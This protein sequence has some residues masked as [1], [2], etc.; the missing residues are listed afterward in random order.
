MIVVVGPEG[1][2]T[3]MLTELLNGCGLEAIQRSL[4]YAGVWWIG[5]TGVPETLT[6]P[7][8]DY[9]VIT[10]DPIATV[11]STMRRRLYATHAIACASWW[12]AY[13]R[14]RLL[15]AYRVTYEEFVAEP[16][17]R[18]QELCVAFGA[19]MP[20]ALPFPVTDENEKWRTA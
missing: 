19:T 17:R 14:C 10:R 2:G 3:N 13:E 4:P 20:T 11:H 7:E 6:L 8:E 16:L 1:S 18:L 9:V 12:V 15:P 5:P